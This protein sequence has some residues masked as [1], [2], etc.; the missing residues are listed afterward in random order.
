MTCQRSASKRCIVT[1][2]PLLYP[3]L[4]QGYCSAACSDD[5]SALVFTWGFLAL[6]PNATVLD[7]D[8]NS[9]TVFTGQGAND[10]VQTLTVL[11]PM[12]FFSG[13]SNH[14]YIFNLTRAFVLILYT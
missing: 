2:T 6:H 3:P 14:S 13:S 12:I 8:F 11:D 10:C 4:L 5:A 7:L 1:P 9:S